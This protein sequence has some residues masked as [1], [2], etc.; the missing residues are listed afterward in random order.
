MLRSPVVIHQGQTVKLIA[1]GQGFRVSSEGKAAPKVTL[2]ATPVLLSPADDTEITHRDL[3]QAF[4]ELSWRA[5]GEAASYHLMLD[6]STMFNR[7]L[8][9]QRGVNATSQQ[10][11]GLEEGRYYWRVAAIGRDGAEGSFSVPARFT[12]TKPAPA[13]QGVPPPLSLDTLEVRTTILHVKGRTEPGAS[14]V[15][16]GQRIDVQADGSF[17]E[18]ITLQKLGSQEVVIRSTGINGGVAE[19]RRTVVAAY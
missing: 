8:Y 5:V 7:P 14:V 10:F 3:A 13:A 11:R 2:P 19:L 15:V 1:Q 12:V 4:T 18:F 6:Y 16:N 17:N 9:D